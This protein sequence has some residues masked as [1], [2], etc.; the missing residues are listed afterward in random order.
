MPILK[1]KNDILLVVLEEVTQSCP[2]LKEILE[3]TAKNELTVEEAEKLLRLLAIAEV[4]G[5]A[6][7]DANRE[8]RK[9]IPEIILAENKTTKDLVEI[10]LRMLSE[11][12]QSNSEQMQSKNKFKPSTKRCLTMQPA[13]L[14]RKQEWSS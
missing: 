9:G 1:S 6:K 4:E 8:H 13:R 14:T 5:I 11:N 10:T 12:G 7:I 2:R 3:K